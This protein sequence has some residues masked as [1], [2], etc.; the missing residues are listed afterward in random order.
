[1]FFIPF[2]ITKKTHYNSLSKIFVYLIT[3][4]I[5]EFLLVFLANFQNQIIDWKFY[6]IFLLSFIS[7]VNYYEIGYIFNETETIKRETDPTK[8]LT[9][10]QLL[11]Y[12]KHKFFIYFERVIITVILNFLLS[13]LISTQSI[14]LFCCSEI[15]CLIIFFVYNCVRGG[16]ITQIIYLFLSIFK[17]ITITFCF[18]EMLNLSI[19]VAGIFVFPIVRTIEY[20]AHYGEDS[21]VNQFFRKYIIKY[22]I[23]KIPVFRVFATLILFLISVLLVLLNICNFIPVILCGY[24]FLYRFALWFAVKLGANFKGYLKR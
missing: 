5:P 24:M 10:E 21:N 19:F 1:M 7:F 9:E 11:F 2:L 15:I 3:Y 8:R 13:F 16:R 17:Y 14:I 23:N 4:V 20:K 12:E 6:I 18:S 22:N